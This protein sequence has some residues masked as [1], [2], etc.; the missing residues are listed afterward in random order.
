MDDL[1]NFMKDIWSKEV[2]EY[3]DD[4]LSVFGYKSKNGYHCVMVDTAGMYIDTVFDNVDS[5]NN[6]FIEAISTSRNEPD[7]IIQAFDEFGQSNF[8]R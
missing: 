6:F 2:L 7:L 3:N 4:I 5:V 1:R 8:L